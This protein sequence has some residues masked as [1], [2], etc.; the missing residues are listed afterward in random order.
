MKQLTG[1]AAFLV[2]LL[3]TPAF[4]AADAASD[5][6]DGRAALQKVEL[7]KALPL[8]KSAAQAL[9]ESVEAQLTL[10][11][12]HLRMGNLDQALIQFNAVVKL[13]PQHEQ[14][15][16][17]VAALTGRQKSF[18]QQVASAK[19]LI[20]FENYD[21]AAGVMGLALRK[22]L[23]TAQKQEALQLLAEAQLW[24]GRTESA[25]ETSLELMQNFTDDGPIYVVASMALVLH[26]EPK[27]ERAEKMLSQAGDLEGVW[28][29]RA[30][31]VK[32]LI[33]LG[34]KTGHDAAS[35]TLAVSMKDIPQGARRT[36]A[37]AV[38][39]TELLRMAAVR[40]QQGDLDGVLKIV[41]PM[42]SSEAAVPTAESVLKPLKVHTGWV[43]AEDAPSTTRKMIVGLLTNLG[44]AEFVR[45]GSRASLLGYWIATELSRNE[46]GVISDLASQVAGLSRPLKTRKSGEVLSRA[47][48]I[49]RELILAGARTLPPQT[50]VSLITAHIDRYAKAKD[51]ETGLAQF[52][53]VADDGAVTLAGDLSRLA[54]GDPERTVLTV[55]A[56][57]CASL[58][59]TAF[60]KASKAVVVIDAGGLGKYDI[61][62]LNLAA[63]IQAR[64]SG[65]AASNTAAM[66]IFERLAVAAKWDDA[67]KA[68]G[69]YYSQQPDVDS[70]WALA[71]LK[72]R[73]AVYDEDR[74]LAA[75]RTLGNGLSDL[76][77]EV[78]ADSI[79][80]LEDGSDANRSVGIELVG[81]LISRYSSLGRSDLASAVLGTVANPET[82]AKALFD[83]TLW[84]RAALLDAEANRTLAV[85]A[86]ASLDRTQLKVDTNHEAELKIL[87]ELITKHPESQFAAMAVEKVLALS[88]HYQAYRAWA[89]ARKIPA[90]FM[91][92]IPKLASI[93]RF[94]YQV[95]GV[96]I[97]QAGAAFLERKPAGKAPEALLAEDVAV[98]DALAAFL[99]DHPVGPSARNAED[100]LFAIARRYG[101]ADGWAATR[102][103][104][105]RFGK[106][107]PDF[108]SPAHLKL[109]EA[110]TYLGELNRDQGL[111][112]LTPAPAVTGP[113]G[114][115]GDIYTAMLDADYG[116]GKKDGKY[117]GNKSGFAAFGGGVG[118]GGKG[119]EARNSPFGRPGAGKPG[120]GK[121][122]EGAAGGKPSDDSSPQ[123]AAAAETPVTPLPG[124]AGGYGD[125]SYRRKSE[126]TA[127]SLAMIR[128]AQAQQFQRL[129]MLENVKVPADPAQ[130]GGQGGQEIVLPSGT[131]LSEAEMKRQ[132]DAADA[133]Y[134]ILIELVKDDAIRN[135]AI[136]SQSRA[137]VMWLFGFFEG[138]LRADRAIVLI[139][140]YLKDHTTDPERVALAYRVVTDRLSFAA[141]RNTQ[142]SL[143]LIEER[144]Q[145]FEQARQEVA[146]FIKAYAE[147]SGWVNTARLLVVDSYLQEAALVGGVSRE[148][149]S[150]L[151]VQAADALL[152]LQR[153]A[154]DHPQAGTFATRLW[155]IAESL[156]VPGNN[157]ASI[158]VLRH[159]AVRFPTSDL[160]GKSIIRTAQLYAQNLANPIRAVETYQEYLSKTDGDP[161]VPTEIFNIATQLAAQQ[162]YLEALHVYGVFVD[163]FPTDS[164]AAAAL[165]AIGQ[166]HQK[167]E[168][169][170]EAIA[171]YER[172]FEEYPTA[173]IVPQTRLAV[174]ECRINLGEW[175]EAKDLYADFAA[176]YPKDGNAAMAK[177][178]IDVLKKLAQF[179]DL[180]ADDM[181]ERNKDDAQFQIGR[182]VLA[183]LKNPIK[184][185][186]EFRKVVKDFPKSDLADDAQ[187][188][189]GKA[190]LSLRQMDEG[191]R[192]LLLI[193]KLYANS[194]LADDALHLVGQSFETQ[195]IALAAVT[196]EK[197]REESF[198]MEQKS[199]YSR[200]RMQAD[201]ATARDAAERG[202]L[203]KEGNATKLALNEASQAWLRGSSHVDNLYCNVT[204]AELQ[205]ETETALQIAN[206]QD[207]IN[208]AYRSAV[209]M[210]AQAAADYPLG[211][212]TDR[213]LIRVAE[214]LETRLKDRAAAMATYQNIVKLFP[215]T[216]VAEDAAWKVAVFYVEEAKYAQAVDGFQTFIR[217]YPA[218]QRVADAQ[219]AMAEVLEQMGKWN[220]AM[221]AYEVF[222]QK[223]AKHP[224]VQLAARQITWIK[225]YRK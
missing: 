32:A 122:G 109:L 36:N 153:T 80:I 2:A 179:Q 159:I 163:S 12:C 93:E 133:A 124:S 127:T 144:H 66:G 168:V 123:A 108:R 78:L 69:I 86:R 33:D 147:E 91:T 31:V 116:N 139:Q 42:I 51:L 112:L 213:S 141:R 5:L 21:Q 225:T 130:P 203:K 43:L 10:G 8:L 121:P 25:L 137:Q 20:E 41:W 97:G 23:P 125:F 29:S 222:R 154:P 143:E 24:A 94:Q 53:T 206:R 19:L 59:Q 67:A 83:W 187:L 65:D 107:I 1:L 35:R 189:I 165:H 75:R 54:P 138:N 72:I 216:P 200:F 62:T 215:G 211:D 132:D 161:S 148:R 61:A 169:W 27:V 180:L 205:A 199:A 155:T 73:R 89:A 192:E 103:V 56:K 204:Q 85:A 115:R 164:R 178:R 77:K 209:E 177:A 176:K 17:M 195:A 79:K 16:K 47:D 220:D 45:D 174:A 135:Q 99:K 52:A 173:P 131:V 3:L 218:S 184:A 198:V 68:I 151:K 146:D 128:Q 136:A 119:Y 120:E 30:A 214:I 208:D 160:A 46:S 182:T 34:K 167:N 158:S 7:E 96:Q 28:K 15:T 191:R 106:A 157:E 140:R 190:L 55:I 185:V 170:E 44:R 181:I 70:G 117:P 11:E 193:P 87:V 152:A 105:D 4:A 172:L 38:A 64:Y 50:L 6:A 57:N 118:G 142:I 101:Q 207:R 129:A 14:A 113:V 98:I 150:G 76:I 18:A 13:S 126:P 114:E 82:G 197:A 219:F 171:S 71:R 39:K 221:D 202:A 48:A 22:T 212:M 63:R 166:T 37:R 162:R 134:A 49:Q 9:P 111:A 196:F 26:K 40:Q 194:P 92:A 223:F 58:G 183:D 104:I 88:Q 74:L 210:Y 175:N 149:A 201:V 81:G 90:D 84:T 224:K 100:Q 110:A 217:N 102:Q 60:Q 188:E 186:A 145:Q 95:I 156:T